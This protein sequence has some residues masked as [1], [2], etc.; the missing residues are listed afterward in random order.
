M[1]QWTNLIVNPSKTIEY[2]FHWVRT[3]CYKYTAS[4][5]WATVSLNPTGFMSFPHWVSS[6]GP[7]VDGWRLESTRVINS[8]TATAPTTTL[9]QST[10][11]SP[12]TPEKN[13]GDNIFSKV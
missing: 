2:N 13:N 12:S 4:I 8:I 10:Q 7:Y 5:D 3:S 1:S 6:S 11:G 9:Q